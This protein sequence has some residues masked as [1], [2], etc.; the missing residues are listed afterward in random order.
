M[1]ECLRGQSSDC[2]LLHLYSLPWLFHQVSRFIYIIDIPTHPKC[3]ISSDFQTELFN[4]LHTS[5]A[6]IL[7]YMSVLMYLKT[8]FITPPLLTRNLFF[9]ASQSHPG[10]LTPDSLPV[11]PTLATEIFITCYCISFSS[12]SKA[13]FPNHLPHHPILNCNT[14]PLSSNLTNP[15]IFSYYLSPCEII[16][17]HICLAV[18]C[19]HK[20]MCPMRIQI[21]TSFNFIFS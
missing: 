1:W 4:Y 8:K 16:S 14:H 12:F 10:T 3:I 9:P 13:I 6:W 2:F 15:L 11:W 7:N 18:T 20:N 17:L 19:S 21:C 5:P